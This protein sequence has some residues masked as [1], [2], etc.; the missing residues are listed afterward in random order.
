MGRSGIRRKILTVAVLGLLA[1][2][3]LA[4]GVA[5]ASGGGGCGRPVTD[6]QGTRITIR[7]FC[8]SPTILRVPPGESV[9]W[10]NKDGVSHNVLGANAVWGG[11][12]QL[13]RGGDVTYQ[14]VRPGVYPYVCTYHPGMVG[15]VVVGTAAGPGAAGVT[16][17][18]AGPVTQVLPT[19]APEPATVIASAP[20]GARVEPGAWPTV[21]LVVVG[22]F[23]A[24]AV[25]L[26]VQR[27]RRA[28][29]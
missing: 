24:A 3:G 29:T 7:G 13:R 23:L 16:T 20:V 2:A 8:F 27:R 14:F 12:N 6:E 15:A 17:T 10:V 11:F 5:R 21:T 4:P 26:I 9:T 25:A 1:S 18:Q 22:L 28:T 19:P